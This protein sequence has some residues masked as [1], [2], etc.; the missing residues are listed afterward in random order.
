MIRGSQSEQD[1]R[2]L[3]DP[4]P[5]AASVGAG[6]NAQGGPGV[7]LQVVQQGAM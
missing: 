7:T 3:Q 1:L 5:A 2:D 4:L 6:R